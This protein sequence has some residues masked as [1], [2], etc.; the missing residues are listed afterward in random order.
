MM[1]ILLR[2]AGGRQQNVMD[3]H[4]M[5]KLY[6]S[7]P[8][9][10]YDP[11]I[12][13]IARFRYQDN[14]IIYWD[15]CTSDYRETC[16]WNRLLLPYLSPNERVIERNW[17]DAFLKPDVMHRPCPKCGAEVFY[18]SS[19]VNHTGSYLLELPECGPVPASLVI[20]K[21]RVLSSK[22]R[23]AVFTPYLIR[24]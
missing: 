24:L 18:M 19:K 16:S 23:K 17:L 21:H 15:M 22:R 12:N 7:H 3:M 13:R 11:T 8:F 20:E 2:Q 1:G 10:I 9:F 6:G 5:N 4:A 14:V